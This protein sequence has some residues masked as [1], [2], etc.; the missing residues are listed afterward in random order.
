MRARRAI[1]PRSAG[2]CL[3]MQGLA[4]ATGSAAGTLQ[5]ASEQPAVK[6]LVARARAR[7][8]MTFAAL[9]RG[10]DGSEHHLDLTN[11]SGSSLRTPAIASPSA[12]MKVG[13]QHDFFAHL[14]ETHDHVAKSVPLGVTA[15][16]HDTH[17]HVAHTA[18]ADHVARA[19]LARNLT[20]SAREHWIRNHLE[21]HPPSL[22]PPP[23]PPSQPPPRAPGRYL[24]SMP[25]WDPVLT[26]C[27]CAQALPNSKI[28]ATDGR[29]IAH[30]HPLCAQLQRAFRAEEKDEQICAMC[31]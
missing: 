28:H 18:V 24:I 22:H 3:L 31:A 4:A 5:N 11:L 21:V 12:V 17:D 2:L 7:Q 10:T 25:G 1:G 16:S 26:K 27:A 8:L 6:Q 23:H 30:L 20:T 9:S 29:L 14:H 19:Y 15:H 13:E